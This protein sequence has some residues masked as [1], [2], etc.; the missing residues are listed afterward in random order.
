MRKPEKSKYLTICNGYHGDTTGAMSVCGPV[1]SMHSIYE[2]YLTENIFAKGPSMISMLPTSGLFQK[3]GRGKVSTEKLAWKE[4]DIYDVREKTRSHHHEL[5]A[6]ILKPILQ[7]I[8]G[9]RL[10][11]PQFLIEL[12]K[13]C[14][15]Y[16]L[17][18]I[19]DD[20]ATGLGRTGAVFAFHHCQ[21]Y[22]NQCGIP[23]ELQVDVYPDIICVGKALTGGYLTLSAV[24]TTPQIEFGISL[25]S[26][27]TGG[28]M[29][30]GPT[31]MGNPLACS[32]A[33]KNLDILMRGCWKKQV[34]GIEEQ[35]F[36]ELFV[37][38]M[39]KDKVDELWLV[40]EVRVVGAVGV[41]EL[42]RPVD[43]AW[44]Q[45]G[46]VSKG[47]YIIPFRNLCYVMPPYIIS[48]EELRKVTSALVSV[49]R[50]WHSVIDK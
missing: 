24:V 34:D 38:L 44:F 9:M 10:Y 3:Y 13:L 28:C 49:L 30:H 20:I 12:R 32:V 6:I 33:N 31:F 16:Q 11:H 40:R 37:P 36:E 48:K 23:K 35:L 45:K 42:K 26:S 47:V 39:E 25:P 22:Q 41:I 8:G 43:Q 2:G 5:C 17:P 21:I 19:L 18:L 14:N 7:G 27:P 15:Q 46:F 50:E 1:G 4:Q 29:M